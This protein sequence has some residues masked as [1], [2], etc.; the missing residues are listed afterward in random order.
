MDNTVGS[1]TQLQRSLIIGSVL[2]DGYIRIMPGRK[3]AFLEVNHSLK[4]KDYVDWKYFVL[5]NICNS[6]PKEMETN[7]GR[8]AYRFFTK[9]DKEITEI[10]NLFY[11]DG[12][13]IISKELEI[14]PIVLA[15]WLMDDG[16]KSNGGVYL[17]TQQFSML[18]QKRLL[19][20]L[21]EIGLRARLNRDK[22]YYRIRFLKESIPKLIEIV[23]PHIIP[24]MRYKIEL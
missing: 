19:H 5:K 18:D 11:R 10:Y 17:N 20:K 7:E 21:R 15:V 2:G 16:S 13:K 23:Q 8:H 3:D 14:N 22:K 12:K 24:S 1:L 9:Q 4:A 6:E